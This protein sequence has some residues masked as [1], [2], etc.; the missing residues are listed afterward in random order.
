MLLAA[1]AL[2]AATPQS[3]KTAILDTIRHMEDAWN[4]VTSAAIWQASRTPT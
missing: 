1:L 4:R 2:A 3:D